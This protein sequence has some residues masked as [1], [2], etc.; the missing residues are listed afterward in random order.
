[1]ED[2]L[3]FKID[4]CSRIPLG[5]MCQIEVD[6]TD[7][8]EFKGVEVGGIL[9]GDAELLLY[10]NNDEHVEISP[11]EPGDKGEYMFELSS[12]GIIEFNNVYPYLRPLADMTEDER[13]EHFQLMGLG[14]MNNIMNFYITHFFDYQ[15]WIEKGW[16]YRAPADMYTEKIKENETRKK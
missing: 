10:D 1:M 3:K 16:A 7:Y 11:D 8:D 14:N 5:L 4:V 9:K 15:G 13:K 12:D 6:L 2:F